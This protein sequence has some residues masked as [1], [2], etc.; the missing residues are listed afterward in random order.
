[1]ADLLRADASKADVLKAGRSKSDTR[2]WA[3]DKVILAYFAGA[4]VVILGW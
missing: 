4:V 1:M 2:F 3:V